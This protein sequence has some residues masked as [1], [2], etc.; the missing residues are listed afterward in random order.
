VVLAHPIKAQYVHIGLDAAD[1]VLVRFLL[2]LNPVDAVC[3]NALVEAQ[4][5]GGIVR[6]GRGLVRKAD[7]APIPLCARMWCALAGYLV[8]T[9]VM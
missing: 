4:D 5:S 7:I 3:V 9:G 2:L 6:E 1:P 8:E